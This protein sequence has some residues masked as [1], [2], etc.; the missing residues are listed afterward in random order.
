MVL[1]KLGA[2]VEIE[3]GYVSATAAKG[4][5]GAEIHFPKVTVG[6]TH[7]ALMAA[8]L[9]R[10]H[11]LIVNAARE[12]EIVD[13]ADCLIKMG[14]RIK[15]AGQSTIEIEGVA[16]LSGARHVVLPD[17][18]EA[19]TYAIAVAMAG[20]DVVL[21]GASADLLESAI[22]AIE[23]AGATISATNQ[24]LRVRRNG[25]GL[26]PVDITTAPFPG[27]PTDL[28][29]QF[30]ALMTKAKGWSRITETIFETASC[31]CRNWC[32]SARISGSLATSPWSKGWTS[33]KARR[34]RR[35]IFAHRSPSSSRRSWRK[36]KPWS[37]GSI[38]LTAVSNV[39]RKSS[40]AA[41]QSS[42]G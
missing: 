33:S 29:A 38:T 37:I 40:A 10:G 8:S 6:G 30:M 17:R 34:S 5:T 32:G 12:P 41:A 4:L 39:S 16:S 1:E 15:G 21:E 14:A 11:T 25:A 9:A 26:S 31:M 22:E 13:L 35:P 20:G 28:Q 18:I 3:A 23:K 2:Q 42:N 27:F 19:G 36:A 24:G 7:T